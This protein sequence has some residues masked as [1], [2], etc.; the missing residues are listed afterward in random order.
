ML[1]SIAIQM[2]EV[3]AKLY[4][5]HFEIDDVRRQNLTTKGLVVVGGGELIAPLQ[6]AVHVHI[7]PPIC[8][9]NR[10]VQTTCLATLTPPK[11]HVPPPPLP[12]Q[13][14]Y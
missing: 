10:T 4:F 1:G 7:C 6:I 3:L 8:L 2:F 13:G 11:S 12:R 14:Q 9:W 5:Y